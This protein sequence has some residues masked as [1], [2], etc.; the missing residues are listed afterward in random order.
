VVQVK[1]K[2]IELKGVSKRC[3]RLVRDV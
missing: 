1:S 2:F 3:I